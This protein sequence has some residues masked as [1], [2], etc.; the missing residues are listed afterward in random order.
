[1]EGS[2][3][4]SPRLENVS[5]ITTRSGKI[6]VGVEKGVEKEKMKK[7]DDEVIVKE[8]SKEEKGNEG[9]K[10]KEG[11][12]NEKAKVPYPN[13]LLKKSLEKQFS[14]FVAMFKK[15]QVD[16]PFSEVLEKMPQEI[17]SKKRWLSEMDE[18]V[19][20]TEECSAI[21]QRKFPTKMKDPGSFTL[22]VEFEGQEEVKALT[23][24]GASVNL[25]PLSMFE[26]LAIGEL[27]PTMMTLQLADCSL[28]TP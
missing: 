24:L 9:K 5:A 22:P 13:A 28:V 23:D 11:E 20:M 4:L 1:M 15:L 19:E 17:L 26:R 27:K 7:K 25:M 14:K 16:I 3:K 2:H 6:L 21:L 10:I 12:K 18:T 8:V